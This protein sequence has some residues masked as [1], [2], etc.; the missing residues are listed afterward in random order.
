MPYHKEHRRERALRRD[1]HAAEIE[2]S[3]AGLRASI[4]ETERLMGE[5][6]EMVRRH[7]EEC[8]VAERDEGC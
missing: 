4:K 8:D 7:R 5:S 6:D 1:R 2:A 3:Q